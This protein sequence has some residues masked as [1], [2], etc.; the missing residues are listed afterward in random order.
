MR[1]PLR[2]E[3]EAFRFLIVVIA[4]AVVIA[5]LAYANKWAGVVAAVLVVG[6]IGWWLWRSPAAKGE[7]PL[8]RLGSS[9]PL[10]RH[11]VLLVAPPQAE[12]GPVVRQLRARVDGGPTEVLVVVPALA[13]PLEAVTGDVDERRAEAQRA[14]LDLAERLNGAGLAARGTVG[15]DEP[16]LAAEDALREFGADEV[17][18]V[19]DEPLLEQARERIAVPVSLLS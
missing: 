3:T 16:L 8:E 2:T 18:L 4:G 9:T 19:G 14:A 6:G 1:N 7:G 12:P 10:G 5:A 15:A 17:V 13:A 11:R